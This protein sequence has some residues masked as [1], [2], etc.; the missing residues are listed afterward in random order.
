MSETYNGGITLTFPSAGQTNTSTLMRTLFR[1][2]SDH[3]HSGSG[4][5][6]KLSINSNQDDSIDDRHVRLRNNEW[7]R[8][9]NGANSADTN[10]LRSLANGVT[11]ASAT[12]W[13]FAAIG[14]ASIALPIVSYTPSI[15]ATGGG[16]VTSLS[17]NG[18]K[19]QQVGSFVQFGLYFT[20]VPS[21]DID[22]ILISPPIFGQHT[23]ALSSVIIDSVSGFAPSVAY[24]DNQV[25]LQKFVVARTDG[26]RM[27]SSRSYVIL[28]SGQYEVA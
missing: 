16:T 18:G 6:V 19:Y 3:D 1:K 13:S 21:G 4:N 26:S 17:Y 7:L 27:F 22:N 24:Y 12:S 10:I 25:G 9:R 20:Y 8:A 28:V 11:D 14:A 15:I 23:V 5:G 2:L